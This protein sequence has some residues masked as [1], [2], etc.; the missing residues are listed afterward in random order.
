MAVPDSDEQ[1]VSGVLGVWSS[2]EGAAVAPGGWAATASTVITNKAA[3]AVTII[4][5]IVSADD[6]SAAYT[7]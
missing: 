4:S 1:W 6:H 2:R 7:S 3:V 5:C